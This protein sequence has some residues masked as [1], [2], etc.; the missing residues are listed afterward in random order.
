MAHRTVTLD[1]YMCDG[2]GRE[3]YAAEDGELP[4]GFH[5]NVM[6]VSRSG[7]NGGPFYACRAACLRKAVAAAAE[8]R[9]EP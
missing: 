7:G 3:R 5:G 6:E 8:R 4:Y 9:G 2:C 1:S